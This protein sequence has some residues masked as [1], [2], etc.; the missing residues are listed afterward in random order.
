MKQAHKSELS[1]LIRKSSWEVEQ[2]KNESNQLRHTIE[3]K[4]PTLTAKLEE[5]ENELQYQ[6]E[7]EKF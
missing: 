5:L 7:K 3:T 6:L 2:H 4:L 1:N